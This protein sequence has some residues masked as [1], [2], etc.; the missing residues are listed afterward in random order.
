MAAMAKRGQRIAAIIVGALGAVCLA[1]TAGADVVERGY[2]VWIEAGEMYF[3]IGAQTGVAVDN[4]VRVKRPVVL[5]HP[6]TRKKVKDELPVGALR[7]RQVG[8][9]LSMAV[10]DG[11]LASEVRVGD[12]VE[13]LIPDRDPPAPD[14]PAPQ[15]VEPEPE[16]EP[17]PLPEVD[18]DTAAVLAVWAE[19]AGQRLDAR[20]AR[21]QAFLDAHAETPYA[22]AV[23]E[24]FPNEA[25]ASEPRVRGIAHHAPSH[26]RYGDPVG[27]AF[28]LEDPEAIVAA[29]IH[30]RRTGDDTYRRAE[31]VRDG[32]SYLRVSLPPE[33]AEDP[34]IEYFVEA[35]TADGRVGSAVGTPMGP[36]EVDVS[37]PPSPP[38]IG[39]RRRRSRVSVRTTYLDFAT[40]DERDG[41][42]TDEFW[43]F[44]ADF[45]LRLLYGR[46]YGVRT[47]FGVINGTGGFGDDTMPEDAGF[48]YGYTELEMRATQHVAGMLRL[49]AGLGE[50]GLG[51]GLEAR[52]RAGHED[53]TN[54]TFAVSSLE[55]V[56]FLSE[57]RMQWA[58]VPHFPVGLAVG[59]TD[60]PNR[61]DLGVRLSTDIGW[62]GMDWVQPTLRLSYQ[63]RNLDHHGLGA[64]L[65]LVFDW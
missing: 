36:I 24:R 60:R 9:A 23:R 10:L 19:T 21:W 62:G 44:E 27:L 34:G 33:A 48:N 53:L 11:A 12:V 15:P 31:L 25:S 28:A 52:L 6:V 37:P 57:I 35:A 51:F 55:E 20:I 26:A 4:A 14:R 18:P 5:E 32:D 46:L 2:V 61:G 8:D 1:P 7:V 22:D 50:E 38:L 40:F 64:G 13:V 3:D 49:I 17:E 43:E 63:G 30:Y 29:W 47:G 58:V 42:H 41:D 16:P 65:G 56:G 54:L 39:E 59:V 45:L